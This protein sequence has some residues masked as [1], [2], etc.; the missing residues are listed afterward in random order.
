[1][2]APWGAMCVLPSWDSGVG[3]QGSDV[4]TARVSE[5]RRPFWSDPAALQWALPPGSLSRRR[6]WLSGPGVV[7][8][9]LHFY[10]PQRP[11]RLQE[12]QLQNGSP[13]P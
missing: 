7:P 8:I 12:S 9:S 13:A 10:S 5:P 3:G 6:F 11:C 2:T 1:M 4:G